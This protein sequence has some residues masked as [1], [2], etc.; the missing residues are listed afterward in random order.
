MAVQSSLGFPV[1][2]GKCKVNINIQFPERGKSPPV[3]L[4]IVYHKPSSQQ[5]KEKVPIIP[6]I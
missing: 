5:T 3:I 6:N 1:L 4:Y 2:H